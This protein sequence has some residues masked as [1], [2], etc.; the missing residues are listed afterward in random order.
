MVV[1]WDGVSRK[2]RFEV[3]QKIECARTA[4]FLHWKDEKVACGF[5]PAKSKTN[6]RRILD[7]FTGIWLQRI[8]V[9]FGAK[10]ALL[11]DKGAVRVVSEKEAIDAWTKRLKK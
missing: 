3:G 7:R 11:I 2:A 10:S 5:V 6:L 9:A 1:V 8:G 4:G